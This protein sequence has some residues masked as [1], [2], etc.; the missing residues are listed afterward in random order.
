MG[1][2]GSL[3][4]AAAPVALDGLEARQQTRAHNL[5]NTHTP[6]FTAQHVDFESGLAAAL[7]DGSAADGNVEAATRTFPTP[8]M[9]DAKG[10]TVNPAT[11]LIGSQKDQL[12]RDG[13]VAVLNNQMTMLRTALQR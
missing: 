2:L 11:E 7:A 13:L 12:T 4:G 6:G 1:P 9:P 10:N 5:A 8:T 3:T